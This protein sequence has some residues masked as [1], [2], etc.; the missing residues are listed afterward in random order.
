VTLTGP[1]AQACGSKQEPWLE[2][3]AQIPENREIVERG[4]IRDQQLFSRSMTTV[5]SSEATLVD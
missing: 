1:G 5:R 4:L 2:P 3:R